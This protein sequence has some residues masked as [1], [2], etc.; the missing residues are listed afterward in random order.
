MVLWV[1]DIRGGE[2]WM[3]VKAIKDVE[4]IGLDD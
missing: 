3:R 2:K 1:Q 4:L